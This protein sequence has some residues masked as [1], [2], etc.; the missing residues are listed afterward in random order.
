MI[1]VGRVPDLGDRVVGPGNTA[2]DRHNAD[3]GLIAT[4]YRCAVGI[5]VR[6]EWLALPQVAVGLPTNLRGAC[7]E[8][9]RLLCVGLC[10]V[11]G[12]ERL[13]E[14]IRETTRFAERLQPL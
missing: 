11:D 3:L 5:D 10:L 1:G 7:K 12:M 9:V 6:M 2:V 8:S 14:L 13:L 4:Y